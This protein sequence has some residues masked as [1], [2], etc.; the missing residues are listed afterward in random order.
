M[1]FTSVYFVSTADIVGAVTL[2]TS[3]IFIDAFAE[4]DR[5]PLK[6]GE[7]DQQ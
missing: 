1:D 2:V 7:P 5:A 3:P 6:I 4:S